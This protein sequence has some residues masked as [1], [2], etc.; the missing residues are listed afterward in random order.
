MPNS[1]DTYKVS[2]NLAILLVGPPKSGKTGIAAAFPAPYFLEID[3]NLDSA[4]R[5]L[6]TKKFWYDLPTT[7]V[8]T[9]DLVWK[10]SLTCLK[11]AI[12]NPEIKT[13]VIDSVSLLSEYMCAWCISEHIRMGETDKGGK[14]ITTMTIPDYGKLLTMFRGLIFDLRA[15][16]KYVVVTSHLQTIQ[17]ELTKVIHTSLAVPGQAKDSLGGLFTD[18]WGTTATPIPGTSKVQYELR[19]AP[20]GTLNSIGTSIRSLPAKI[21]F[22]GK[23]P[24]EIWTMLSPLIGGTV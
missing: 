6:G 13:I 7:T 15:S 12:A 11:A 23:T 10:E 19:T 24:T 8:K 3:N 2:N 4:V 14:P 5:V 17:D 22:T 16:G 21:D 1:S 9:P 18:V 20:Y